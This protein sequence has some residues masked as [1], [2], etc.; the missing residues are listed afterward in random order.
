MSG[1][2]APLLSLPEAPAPAGGTAEWVAGAGGARLRAAVFA[3]TN[4]VGTVVLSGGRTEFIEKYYE[5]IGELLARGFT[6]LVHDWRGQGLS[7][8]LLPDR[9]RGHATSF[10]D[11]AAD[12]RALLDHF[13][14]RLPRP[15][16]ALSHSMG[17][18]LTLLALAKGEGRLSGAVLSAPMLGLKAARQWPTRAA[19]WLTSRA[20]AAGLYSL[21]GGRDPFHADFVTDRLTHDPA[22]Y[23]RTRALIMACPELALGAVTWGWVD[24]AFRAIGW[25]QRTPALAKVGIPITI[26]AAGRENLVDNA[27]QRL[28]AGRLPDC[29]YVVI[30]EAFHEIL[31][32]TDEVRAMFWREF[33]ALAARLTAAISPSA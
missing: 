9:L 24:A 11:F 23:A 14:P 2:A 5:V 7:A 13:E 31:M 25:L 3:A 10:D 32:E 22:R 16:I 30:P 15:W 18:C 28:I 4:P 6:V 26:V 8:R 27:G 19:V 33:D 12:Y 21:G 1:Q 17:G 20:G 29:R